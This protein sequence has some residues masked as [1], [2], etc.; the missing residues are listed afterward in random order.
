MF[1]I[2]A[3]IGGEFFCWHNG[4]LTAIYGS[5]QLGQPIAPPSLSY[6]DTLTNGDMLPLREAR[7]ILKTLS[8]HASA[9]LIPVTGDLV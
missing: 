3:E 7:A 8:F 9:Y 6:R 1:K 5:W 4:S 2:C